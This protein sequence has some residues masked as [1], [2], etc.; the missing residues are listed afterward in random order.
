MPRGE[1]VW[2]RSGVGEGGQARRVASGG[3]IIVLPY[4]F[5]GGILHGLVD[6]NWHLFTSYDIYLS[7][8]LYLRRIEPGNLNYCTICAFYRFKASVL[9]GAVAP[10]LYIDTAVGKLLLKIGTLHRK[11]VFI[12]LICVPIVIPLGKIQIC[13]IL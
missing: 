1:G 12:C 11:T 10:L 7:F 3:Y 5:W 9:L 4:F 13:P 6:L 8:G 2:A